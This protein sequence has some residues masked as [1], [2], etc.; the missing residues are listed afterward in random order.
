M[1]AYDLKHRLA[2]EALGTLLLLA[3]VVGSG[4]MA[5]HLAGGNQAVALLANT[6]A[7]SCMLFVLILTFGPVS[8][9]FNPAVSL[10]MAIRRDYRGGVSGLCAGANLPG[11]SRASCWRM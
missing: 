3:A 5:E 2:A 4:I 8:A 7:T 9:H 6:F 1:G 10:V 11:P